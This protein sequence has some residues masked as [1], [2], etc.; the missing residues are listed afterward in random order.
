MGNNEQTFN[1]NHLSLADL[2]EARD[3]FHAHLI[4]KKNVVATA[5]GRY[6]IRLT[7]IDNS[8]RIV[9]TKPGQVKKARTLQNSIV[10]DTS[11]PCILVFVDQWQTEKELIES[12]SSD[13]VPKTIFMP[14]G[15][16]V[17]VCV[18]EASKNDTA[19]DSVE[20]DSLRFP[21]NMIGG[22]FPLLIRSQMQDNVATI[23][24]LVSDGHTFYA[25]TNRHVSGNPGQVVET[26]LG[27]SRVPIGISSGNS[28][29]KIDFTKLY[30]GWK[31]KNVSVNC[32]TGLIEIDDINIWK[33][34]ILGIDEID[35]IYDLNTM[36]FSLGL[37]AE[38]RFVDNTIMDAAN[39]IVTGYGA[40]G[41][42]LKG[43]IAALFYRYKSIGGIEYISDFLIGG[44]NGLALNTD[45]GDS[46][47][48]WL[49]ERLKTKNSG[50][51]QIKT[52]V[53]EPIALHWGKH[54]FYTDNKP[55]SYGYSL[56]TSI[57]NICR[58]LNVDIVRGWNIDLDYSW[59]KVGHY[60]VGNKAIGA[61]H[62]A[63]LRNFMTKN[64]ENISLK[65]QYVNA[66]LDQ[67]GGN[68]KLITDPEK[69][70]CPLA[71]VPDIIWKQYK[72]TKDGKANPWGRKGDENPNHFADADAPTVNNGGTLFDRCDS[73]GKMTVKVWQD[74]YKNI[75]LKAI[76]LDPNKPVTQGL[77]CFR[78]W[79]IFDYMV[80]SKKPEHFIFAAGVLAH[81][82][83]DGCQP[84]HSS[85]MADGNPIDNSSVMYTPSRGGSAHPKGVPYAKI[86]N[87][88]SGVHVAYE[89]TMIDARIGDI[90]EKLNTMLDDSQSAV[91][92]EKIIAINTGQDAAFAVL[93]LM[94][95][96]QEDIPPVDIV[97]TFKKAKKDKADITKALYDAYGEKTVV[98]LARGCLYLAA[99]WEAAWKIGK[100]STR[101]KAAGLVKIKQQ[102]L[103][104]LY[105]DP[106]VLPSMQL[107][108]I[109]AI[110]KK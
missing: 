90:M 97:E 64:L 46:G 66:T 103:I 69:G 79:Q 51:L 57:S 9:P 73:V 48:L 70:F 44:R 22:G 32:D 10:I 23:G 30:P 105:K 58:E 76:G 95:A 16:I 61:I 31:G 109:G 25:L 110:L 3:L 49:M 11:W 55:D 84:L 21:T 96:T 19:P 63:G 59:G 39:G 18:V 85:Y 108:T 42:L 12:E 13:I 50:K 54:S 75:D 53:F 78:V 5:L 14:D 52:I 74:Y 98:I 99:I 47:M 45:H 7:D 100:L 15:K 60:T 101:F 62:V 34:S 6:L 83:G 77:I 37:I 91:N 40:V 35:E 27:N 93:Q 81:Y 86:I 67:K 87:P 43:E 94:K 2:V 20:L 26:I 24:C 4:N 8:C 56:S 80:A 82:V 107:G 106:R 38:H 41:G 29:A 1:F 71:D 68:P 89:D 65:E 72:K 102:L 17:P 36:N 88:G 104:N 33:T 92:K 28:I